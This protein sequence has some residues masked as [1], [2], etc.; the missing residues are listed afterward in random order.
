VV[1]RRTKPLEETAAAITAIGRR[2]ITAPG[3]VTDPDQCQRLVETTL[4]HF[5]R[6]DVLVNNAGGLPYKQPLLDWSSE[7]WRAV[8]AL[9][10]DS[11]W[12]MSRYA[13]APMIEQ[14]KGSIINISSTASLMAH[15]N[16][17]PYAVAKAAVNH[18]TTTLAA[19]LTPHGV[20]VNALALGPIDTDLLGED[21]RRR[22]GKDGSPYPGNAMGRIGQ[23]EE[24]G[25]A[26]HFFASD[27]SNFCSGQTLT[28]NG[29][30]R[31]W[32]APT[33]GSPTGMPASP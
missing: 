23:P 19:G 5:G 28:I 32:G 33:F 9:N 3:D 13:A 24:V 30:P 8:L 20:R 21:M 7:E 6:L 15:P 11:V 1:G 4:A 10:L 26:V 31:N 29:G 12:F 22:F 16:I 14:G 18:L 2:A 25:Y 17:L 27:A